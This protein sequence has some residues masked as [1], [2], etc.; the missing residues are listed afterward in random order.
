MGPTTVLF[1]RQGGFYRMSKE[2][3]E[4]IY[5]KKEATHVH[6]DR[7]ISRMACTY[8]KMCR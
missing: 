3:D 6:I 7:L 2:F 5:E 1:A 8:N 4:E